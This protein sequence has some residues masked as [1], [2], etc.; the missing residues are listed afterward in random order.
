LIPTFQAANITNSLSHF[1]F[2]LLV[3]TTIIIAAGGYIIN[4]IKDYP[5]DII[6]K[7]EKIFVNKSISEK[8]AWNLY[9]GLGVLG[10]LIAVYLAVQ[11]DAIPLLILYPIACGLLYGY[12]IVFKRKMLIGNVIVALFCAFVP[13]I[14]LLGERFSINQLELKNPDL[15]TNIFSI[16]GFYLCF[17]FVSTMYREL[18]KDIE[19]IEG[20]E[21]QGC[22]TFPIVF[23]QKIAVQFTMIIGVVLLIGLLYCLQWQWG[24]EAT[25]FNISFLILCLITP[26]IM[27]LLFLRKAKT[28]KQFHFISQVI[29][30]MMLTGLIYLLFL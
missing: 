23:G 22:R 21:A 1:Q 2:F 13:A 24:M 6:N 3:I 27:S 9:L 17:A 5:I 28:K 19:D 18:V 14:L 8:G 10:A 20:D 26:L 30:G 4:D 11:V 7:P 25:V 29:K 12:A 15:Y 16:F